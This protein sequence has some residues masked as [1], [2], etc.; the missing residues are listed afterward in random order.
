MQNKEIRFASRPA[1]MPMLENFQFIDAEVPHPNDGEVLVRM[2]YISVDPYLRGRMREGRS[3]VP[4]F[5]VGQM[6]ESGGVGEV[7]ESRSPRFQPGDIVTGR[8]WLATLQRREG[9][10]FDESLSNSLYY[11]RSRR[12]RD[13]APSNS[14]LQREAPFCMAGR[15]LSCLGSV[16]G[17]LPSISEIFKTTCRPAKSACSATKTRANAPWPISPMTSSMESKV[18]NQKICG[19]RSDVTIEDSKPNFTKRAASS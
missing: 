9:G 14:R 2:L 6:I 4:P 11:H 5:E 8:F 15:R 18:M 16:C 10:W 1:G 19:I 12:S 13:R 3:Y 7:V 17:S